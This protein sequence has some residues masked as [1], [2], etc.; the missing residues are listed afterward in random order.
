MCN[1]ITRHLINYNLIPDYSKV[2]SMELLQDLPHL[3][4][5]NMEKSIDRRQYMTNLL[6][7]YHI[8]K[9]TRIPALDGLITD[10]YIPHPHLR[11]SRPEYG[12][13]SSHLMEVFI[14]QPYQS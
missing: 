11:V 4:W 5:I 12:C 6:E 3:L 8:T 10:S 14:F 2:S 13:V 1:R 9:H 7:D